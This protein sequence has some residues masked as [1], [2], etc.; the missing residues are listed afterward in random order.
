[1]N[2]SSHLG[3]MAGNLAKTLKNSSDAAISQAKRSYPALKSSY[4]KGKTTL[5]QKATQIR[6]NAKS[7][8]NEFK[9]G[10]REERDNTPG[11]G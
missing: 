3:K 11:R 2:I 8:V 6:D 9:E 4:A 10:Y 1:M 5:S 7:M